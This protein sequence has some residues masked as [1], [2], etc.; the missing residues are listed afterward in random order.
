MRRF[1]LDTNIA[2]DYIFKRHRVYERAREEISRGN[3]IGICIPV[4]GELYYGVEYSA[5]RDR[6]A[7]RLRQILPDFMI[8][9][10]DLDA[11]KEFGRVRANLRRAGRPM[12]EV[13]IQT[14]AIALTLGRTTIVTA[15]TDFQAIPGLTLENWATP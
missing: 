3:R 1:L 2:G 9:P 4:V 10:Y 14:A 13:D 11:A 5:T 8:W 15:D 12:Q 7:N 6:N